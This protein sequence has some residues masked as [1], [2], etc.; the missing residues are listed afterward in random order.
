LFELMNGWVTDRET[1]Q[2]IL[3]DDPRE[4]YDA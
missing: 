2:R 1:R 4:L 3:V